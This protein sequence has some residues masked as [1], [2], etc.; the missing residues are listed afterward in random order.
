[1]S[2]WIYIYVCVCLTLWD[3][4]TVARQT[5]SSVTGIFAIS[6]SKGSS[7]SGTEPGLLRLLH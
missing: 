3:P 6:Y 1:M 5:P 2:I 4:W 7:D